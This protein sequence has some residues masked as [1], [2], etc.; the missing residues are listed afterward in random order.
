M[1]LGGRIPMKVYGADQ[2]PADGIARFGGRS[3][4]EEYADRSLADPT[5]ILRDDLSGSCATF[6]F[7]CQGWVL[8]DK[9]LHP[10]LAGGWHHAA[11]RK[12]KLVP[13]SPVPVLC[14]LSS[15][16]TL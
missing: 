13:P 3:M 10:S 15:L 9:C 6:S 5:K 2:S 11:S 8:T 12:Q 1:G 7:D 4:T 14:D 16:S